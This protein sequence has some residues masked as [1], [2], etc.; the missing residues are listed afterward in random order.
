MGAFLSS[1]RRCIRSLIASSGQLGVSSVL[2][3]LG[4]NGGKNCNSMQTDSATPDEAKTACIY[5]TADSHRNCFCR[6]VDKFV[7]RACHYD[8]AHPI[9]SDEQIRRGGS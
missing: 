6:L 9:R 4:G 2:R 1:Q 7:V 3:S 8:R 5:G